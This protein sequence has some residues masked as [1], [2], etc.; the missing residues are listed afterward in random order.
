MAVLPADGCA[1]VLNGEDSSAIQ[2]VVPM[3]AKAFATSAL[4]SPGN[5]NK[6]TALFA[7]YT[8]VKYD[9]QKVG[10][11][12]HELQR[13]MFQFVEEG[14][15]LA[16]RSA[17]PA[18]AQS[19]QAAG[20]KLAFKDIF[21]GFEGTHGN[22]KCDVRFVGETSAAPWNAPI[23]DYG[24]RVRDA[25]AHIE[26][27]VA[28]LRGG[29][30]ASWTPRSL[31]EWGDYVVRV[32]ECTRSSDMLGD[33][34]NIREAALAED[35]AEA[36]GT[37]EEKVSSALSLA[38]RAAEAE[39]RAVETQSEQ[40]H[41]QAGSSRSKEIVSNFET[42]V[43]QVL[44]TQNT[45]LEEI[46]SKPEYS[47]WVET[48]R[49]TWAAFKS[50]A[51][52]YWAEKLRR[53]C[54]ATLEFENIANE[55]MQGFQLNIQTMFAERKLVLPPGMDKPSVAFVERHF[56]PL[57]QSVVETAKL[58]CPPRAHRVTQLVSQLYND[59]TKNRYRLEVAIGGEALEDDRGWR[60]KVKDA[61]RD[62]WRSLD[63]EAM[64]NQLE[65]SV[66]DRLGPDGDGGVGYQAEKVISVAISV[67][68]FIRERGITHH[69]QRVH[70]IVCKLLMDRMMQRELRWEERHNAA[71]LV[72]AAEAGARKTFEETFM[73][74]SDKER[75]HNQL[76]R[77]VVA[78]LDSDLENAI[79]NGVANA[80]ISDNRLPWVKSRHSLM[81]ELDL[82]LLDAAD[83]GYDQ[84]KEV[85]SN[86]RSH[87]EGVVEKLVQSCM[88]GP[89]DAQLD[90][91]RLGLT[92]QLQAAAASAKSVGHFASAGEGI[93]RAAG[94]AAPGP[95]EV[96]VTGL[97]VALASLRQSANYDC[98]RA[99]ANQVSAGAY[100]SEH[101][102]GAQVAE[103]LDEIVR[104]L[105]QVVV[106]KPALQAKVPKL[107]VAALKT[108]LFSRRNL[109]LYCGEPCPFCGMICTKTVGH[110]DQLPTDGAGAAAAAGLRYARIYDTYPQ[111]DT[112]SFN[113]AARADLL[114]DCCHQPAGLNGR[115]NDK[116]HELW[117]LSCKKC[118]ED[119]TDF[120]ADGIL[121]KFREFNKKY[122][123]WTVPNPVKDPNDER[124][125][126][127]EYVFKRYN[128]EL[129][130][131]PIRGIT[132]PFPLKPTP[133][134][135]LAGFSDNA[136]A[137]CTELQRTAGRTGGGR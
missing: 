45:A 20:V 3:V 10:N 136:L 27:R 128:E 93:I 85:L 81:A 101:L 51:K 103:A 33:L 91:F 64:L 14:L 76:Y 48:R 47:K 7:I 110:T 1:L 83:R 50:Q 54:E 28:S 92:I 66:N 74:L 8:R 37:A 29:F 58:R 111:S 73:G 88:R 130:E 118:A 109:K 55:L 40:P 56:R 126:A 34:R 84:V 25:V 120:L 36:V 30:H 38:F 115:I 52:V 16:L 59:V 125:A 39:V 114:H 23:P 68:S 129:A 86:P 9:D 123:N 62:W 71:A 11:L 4:S 119:N 67:E 90:T 57:F 107:V 53:T 22:P 105:M 80:I 133:H 131:Q 89:I 121:Y 98:L 61:L 6:N 32:W 5:N 18:E 99:A 44:K 41:R 104:D 137:L 31:V 19:A 124:L 72:M 12:V 134:H 96:V 17:R 24:A 70:L 87:F 97:S 135:Q 65:T 13:K 26:A 122:P 42:K 113:Y 79:V 43:D 35:L 75:F 2:E 78:A 94:R 60:Q 21:A 127:R 63:F 102:K 82:D 106:V 100:S 117:A 95:G 77:E 49:A 69:A 15:D 116:T 108:P 46:L 132:R 112:H